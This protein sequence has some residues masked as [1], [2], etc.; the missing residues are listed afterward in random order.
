MSSLIEE[1]RMHL[2][3]VDNG[4]EEPDLKVFTVR[5]P[6]E[7]IEKM[8]DIGGVIGMKRTEVAR[9]ILKHGIDEIFQGLQLKV[10]KHGMSFE[11]M[12]AVETGQMTI[13]DALRKQIEE[14]DSEKEGAN[15]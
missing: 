9:M 1:V 7:M 13:E 11:D 8:E 3:I 15:K 10:E 4:Y 12:Y 5:L 2:N 6:I 14:R